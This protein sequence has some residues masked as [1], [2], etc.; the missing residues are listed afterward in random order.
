MTEEFIKTFVILVTII[1]P[2]GNLPAYMA[3]TKKYTE[4]EHKALAIKT[5]FAVF[6]FLTVSFL[7]GK[8]V[9]LFFGIQMSA[10]KLIGGI[11]LLYVA[12]TMIT[13]SK[14]SYLYSGEEINH[15]DSIS[16]MPLTFPLLV[17]PAAI[18]S[19][20]IQSNELT[21][22]SAKIISIMEFIFIGFLIWM[23][24][25]LAKKIMDLLGKTG[26]RFLTQIMGLLLGS[27][28]V[29]FIA[30]ELKVLFPGLS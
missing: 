16:V 29:G 21:A 17:G 2:I 15:R 25:M 13:N 23:T 8:Y 18:S 14:T 11:F 19:V 28:A 7:A 1:D 20:I 22:W 26:I 24:L 27:L 4:E 5:C 9:I 6:V 12:F 30:D 3:L 10:F